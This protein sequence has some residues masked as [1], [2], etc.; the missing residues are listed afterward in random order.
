MYTPADTQRAAH[1]LYDAL[2]AA[3]LYGLDGQAWRAYAMEHDQHPAS[4]P[5]PHAADDPGT[6]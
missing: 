4:V 2:A 5:D 1:D 3:G 6:Y